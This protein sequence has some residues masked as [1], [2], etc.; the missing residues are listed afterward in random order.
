LSSPERRYTTC[1]QELLAV[2]FA[3][4]KFR[5]YVYGRRI[6]MYTD[7]SVSFIKKCVITSN[8]IARWVLLI[9]EYD[10]TLVLIAGTRN[11]FADVLSRNPAGVIAE[12]V[13]ALKRPQQIMVAHIDLGQD[14]TLR[15]DIRNLTGNQQRDPEL[16][17]IR[18][19]VERRC[20]AVKQ[21]YMVHEDLIYILDTRDGNRWRVVVPRELE[22]KL[23]TYVHLEKGH[24]GTDKCIRII[25]G[26]F[27]VKNLGRKTRKLLS[28][29]EI[30]Q[31]VK[32]PSWKYDIETR[33]HL[34]EKRGQL[35]SVDF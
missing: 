6:N 10:L 33:P 13:N 16:R 7:K 25:N 1:E 8:R 18:N 11:H 31:K 9:Q 22:E 20:E 3:L 23:I 21:R 19:L 12:Q 28:L 29:C 34:P 30:C 14:T 27:Y 24:A 5:L 2:V 17:R 32:F 26:M 15:R 4:Q 35:V